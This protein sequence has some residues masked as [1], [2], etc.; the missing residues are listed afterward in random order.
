MK[1]LEVVALTRSVKDVTLT[2][3]MRTPEFG[4]EGGIVRADARVTQEQ[5]SIG[6]QSV[7]EPW[8]ERPVFS[9]LWRSVTAQLN[10]ALQHAPVHGVGLQGTFRPCQTPPTLRQLVRVTK[11]HVAI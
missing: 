5:M 4:V 2:L 7:A 8:N 10:P 9:Q 3:Q 11:L 6:V 1:F